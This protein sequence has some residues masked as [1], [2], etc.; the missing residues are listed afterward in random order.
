[1][2]ATVKVDRIAYDFQS[3]EVE[4]VGWGVSF[5][6]IDVVETIEYNCSIDRAKA[7]GASRDPLLRSEGKAD[8]DGSITMYRYWWNHLVQC[9][10][11]IGCPLGFLELLLPV[12]Y[13]TKDGSIVTDTIAGVRFANI[14]SSIS[15]GAD[16]SMV[17]VPI[18]PMTIYYQGFTVWGEPLG[19]GAPIGGGASAPIQGGT[20]LTLPNGGFSLGGASGGGSFTGG[21]GFSFP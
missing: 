5:G 8:Y 20:N 4:L 18:D 1:M 2:A 10:H 3:L 19:A 16:N 13:K 15:E 7:W 21:G 14:N 6:V 9:A 11:N 17:E 12:S